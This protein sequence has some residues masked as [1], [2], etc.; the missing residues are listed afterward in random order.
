M[1]HDSLRAS[2]PALVAHA[3]PK[4]ARQI[5]CKFFD[6]MPQHNA[7]GMQ[8]DAKLIEGK[9]A[10]H[11][12]EAFIV[13]TRHTKFVAVDKQLAT[14]CPALD[15]KVRVTPYAR[16][17]FAGERLDAIKQEKH[18]TP[19]GLP[20]TV[21]LCRRTDRQQPAYHCDE[22]FLERTLGGCAARHQETIQGSKHAYAKWHR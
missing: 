2:L 10:A 11:T 16:R 12:D 3:T 4:N 17:D 18:A 20:Y 13:K 7:F 14:L 15:D 1:N 19:E 6:N 5:H 9:V 21:T 8:I 22:C